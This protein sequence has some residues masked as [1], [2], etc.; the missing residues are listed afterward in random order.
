VA[1]LHIAPAVAALVALS[2]LEDAA[3][4]QAQS[5]NKQGRGLR[6]NDSSGIDRTLHVPHVM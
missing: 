3:G 5:A 4:R 2:P 6:I 1:A